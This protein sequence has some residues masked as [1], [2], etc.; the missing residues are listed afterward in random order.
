M[1]RGNPLGLLEQLSLSDGESLTCGCPSHQVPPKFNKWKINYQK[2]NWLINKPVVTYSE[3]KC[4]R[5]SANWGKTGCTLHNY[6]SPNL[7]NEET[8]VKYYT[9]RNR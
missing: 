2:L 8:L 3:K 5:I 1:K 9:E 4:P 7:F 6:S